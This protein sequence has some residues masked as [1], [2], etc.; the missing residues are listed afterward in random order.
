[1][2]N[3]VEPENYI[4]TSSTGGIFSEIPYSLWKFQLSIIYF[5]KIFVLEKPYPTN[6]PGNSNPLCAGSMDIFY[7]TAHLGTGRMRLVHI[8][9][10]KLASVTSFIPQRPN[11]PKSPQ[12]NKLNVSVQMKIVGDI[13]LEEA[14]GVLR[15]GRE[16][17]RGGGGL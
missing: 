15:G 4:H 2:L 9:K 8:L 12:P 6:P 11:R 3:C 17:G 16:R 13:S 10:G 5:F 14:R 1:M 7:E